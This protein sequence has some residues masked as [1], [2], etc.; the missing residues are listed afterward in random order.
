M[1]DAVSA[2]IAD[3]WQRLGI[4]VVTDTGSSV[5]TWLATH[6][7]TAAI[8]RPDRYTFALASDTAELETATND[9]A[10][11]VSIQEVNA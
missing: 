10:R 1:T 9:L 2:E 8:V 4:A 5:D 6:S 3:L 11:I 7:A